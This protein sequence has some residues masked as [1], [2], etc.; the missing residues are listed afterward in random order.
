MSFV[1]KHQTGIL[2]STG[3]AGLSFLINMLVPSGIIGSALIALLIGMMLNPLISR[4]SDFD[5]GIIWTSKKI[6]RVG[7][8]LA[9]ITLSFTQVFQA[10]KYALILM[11]FTLT[12]AFGVGYICK[13]IFKINWKLA[14]LLSVSTAICGATAVATVG[15]TIR[16]KNR[17]IAYAI[18]ATFIFDLLTVIL[19]PWFGRL[20][21][22]SDT[23]Y[24]LWIGTAVNDTS[25]VVAAGYAFSDAAGSLATIVKLTRTLFIVPI[26]LIFAW[27]YARKEANAHAEKV[28][29]RKIF[30]WFILGFLGVVAVRST[31]LLS[32]DL[33]SGISFLSKFFLTMALGAVGLRTSLKEVTGVGI[34]PMV[35][36]V[37][38]DTS[39]VVVSLFAQAGI[40]RMFG[41]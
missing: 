28:E 18:S 33:V 39:V 12:T 30:P 5:P 17:D 27:V 20:I 31:G 8:I 19:F 35:A 34:K 7:I 14:S 36:G 41:N 13:K 11:I 10:G 15:P 9:G 26:V 22:L 4:F 21:G 16:A 37:I 29:I 2:L 40:L 38:I 32:A 24:G 6:L 25:S 23:S 3:I 1:K